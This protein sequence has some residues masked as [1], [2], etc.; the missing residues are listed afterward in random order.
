MKTNKRN[1]ATNPSGTTKNW[2]KHIAYL[3]HF[4]LVNFSLFFFFLSFSLFVY[5]VIPKK[6]VLYFCYFNFKNAMLHCFISSFCINIINIYLDSYVYHSSNHAMTHGHTMECCWMLDWS[7]ATI[8]FAQSIRVP[9]PHDL[10]FFPLHYIS[11]S[12]SSYCLLIILILMCIEQL[13][14]NSI[15]RFISFFIDIFLG[16]LCVICN[17][18]IFKYL[19][20]K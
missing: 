4:L 8:Y 1:R 16:F 19:T 3:V 11:S 13:I 9:C 7:R 17:F 18:K 15:I 6:L 2:K 12:S 5:N 14:F 20:L 10:A